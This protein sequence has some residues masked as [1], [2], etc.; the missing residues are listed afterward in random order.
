MFP[1][2]VAPHEVESGYG[3][4]QGNNDDSKNTRFVVGKCNVG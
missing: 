2:A 4:E 1:K 3:M